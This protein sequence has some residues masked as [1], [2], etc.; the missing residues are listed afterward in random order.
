MK[1]NQKNFWNNKLKE[2]DCLYQ[3]DSNKFYNNFNFIKKIIAKKVSL[4]MNKRFDILS[5]YLIKLDLTNKK[6]LEIGCGGGRLTKLLL[7]QKAKVTAVDF[8]SQAIELT[9]NICQNSPNLKLINLDIMNFNNNETYDFVIAIGVIDYLPSLQNFLEKFKNTKFLIYNW[10]DK[11]TI[12][13]YLRKIIEKLNNEKH[14]YYSKYKIKKLYENTNFILKHRFNLGA[15][16]LDIL[17]RS[18]TK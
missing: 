4:S 10:S 15:N 9:Q 18:E 14:Q 5:N 12:K 17:T 2:F 8:S 13:S 7:E 3:S 11:Y 6:I 16:K 1:V